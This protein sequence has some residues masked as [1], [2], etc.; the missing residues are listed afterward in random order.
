MSYSCNQWQALERYARD[1]RLAIDNNPA[2]RAV[3]LVAIGRKNWLFADS[4][5]GGKRAAMLYSVIY[6]CKRM[7]LDPLEYLRDVLARVAAHPSSKIWELTPRGW[8]EACG[9][10]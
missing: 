10:A 8:M 4:E 3:K 5:A 6:T 7:G 9:L 1:G 2:E